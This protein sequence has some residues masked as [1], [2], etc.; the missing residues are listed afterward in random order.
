[1]DEQIAPTL[2]SDPGLAFKL[3]HTG[4][5]LIAA[6]ACAILPFVRKAPRPL[7][8]AAGATVLTAVAGAGAVAA[9]AYKV[10]NRLE[11]ALDAADQ[12]IAALR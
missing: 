5:P 4:V 6:A 2:T 11:S 10:Y 1:M 8:I 7:R 12:R 9:A 3:T